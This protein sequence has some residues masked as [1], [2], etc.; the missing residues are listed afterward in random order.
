MPLLTISV[1]QFL[2]VLFLA[3][4]SHLNIYAV[5]L[6]PPFM[7]LWSPTKAFSN[8]AVTVLLYAAAFGGLS[9]LGYFMSGG[10]FQ[11]IKSTYGTLLFF[12]DLVPNMG[13]WWYFFMEIFD[14]FRPLFTYIFQLYSL[15][16]VLPITIRLQKEPLFAI[17]S[18]LGVTLISKAYPELG[19]LGIYI[20]LLS[21]YQHI[22]TS[23]HFPL[24]II[25]LCQD[26][27]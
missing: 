1:A 3:A 11:Y 4:A 12:S 27:N 26:A 20:S 23:M 18:I 8:C 2:S 15:I 7:I 6:V 22:F 9:L 14:S 10:S 17:V 21:L 5:Y 19:D 25:F 13:L 16:Y 24:N